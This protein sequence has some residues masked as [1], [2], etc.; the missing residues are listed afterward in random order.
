MWQ[1]FP[2]R[3]QVCLGLGWSFLA[4]MGAWAQHD[5]KTTPVYERLI[6]SFAQKVLT[7]SHWDTDSALELMT[8]EAGQQEP[9]QSIVDTKGVKVERIVD[10]DHFQVQR[11]SLEAGVEFTLPKADSYGLLMAIDSGLLIW[12]ESLQPEAAVLLPEASVVA[13]LVNTS[14]E[15]I[16]FLVAYPN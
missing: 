6:L 8:L 4:L 2:M 1:A 10:F 5:I 11:V 13:N 3:R 12:G 14:P 9:H 16:S 15:K 7:Q